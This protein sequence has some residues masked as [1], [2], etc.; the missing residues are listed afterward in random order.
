[1]NN[2]LNRLSG[3]I[4]S[5]PRK[6]KQSPIIAASISPFFYSI[7]YGISNLQRYDRWITMFSLRCVEI[8]VMFI[9]FFFWMASFDRTGQIPVAPD[10]QR[11]L[12]MG[13]SGGN[14]YIWVYTVSCHFRVHQL[15]RAADMCCVAALAR[16]IM[17]RQLEEAAAPEFE[18]FEVS[19][20]S[21]SHQ[22]L[23]LFICGSPI[24]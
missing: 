14:D 24:R 2:N 10:A 16:C 1:M 17:V 21:G 19:A 8:A 5:C 22:R 13:I 3:I 11:P 18:E 6:I 12:W 15:T 7:V 4:P 9:G 20:T 23:R